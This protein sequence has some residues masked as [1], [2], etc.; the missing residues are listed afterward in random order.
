MYLS[1]KVF[2]SNGRVDSQVV[3][4]GRNNTA[5][6]QHPQRKGGEKKPKQM[7]LCCA[8]VC[9][10]IIDSLITRLTMIR[11]DGMPFCQRAL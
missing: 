6:P 7:K 2:H 1:R 3:A 4:S 8:Q 5:P 9:G 11:K 10:L